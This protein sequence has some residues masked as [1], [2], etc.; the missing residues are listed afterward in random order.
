MKPKLTDQLADEIINKKKDL[1]VS[2]GITSEQEIFQHLEETIKDYKLYKKIIKLRSKGLT[3][4]KIGDMVGVHPGTVSHWADKGIIPDLIS[5]VSYFSKKGMNTSQSVETDLIRLL[6]YYCSCKKSL[7][8]STFT[9]S[10]YKKETLEQILPS[11]FNVFHT[12]PLIR[13]CHYG[14]DFHFNSNDFLNYIK[15]NT[16]DMTILPWHIL[17]TKEKKEEFFKY[18][19]MK[20]GKVSW[21]QGECKNPDPR[22]TFS[23]KM[24]PNL[25]PHF[26]MLLCDFSFVPRYSKT[27]IDLGDYLDLNSLIRRGLCI[28]SYK[29]NQLSVALKK[30]REY[31]TEKRPTYKD[32]FIVDIKEKYESKQISREKFIKVLERKKFSDK[33]IKNLLYSTRIPPRERRIK[34]LREVKKLVGDRDVY[35]HLYNNS[36]EPIGLNQIKDIAL[37]ADT[38]FIKIYETIESIALEIKSQNLTPKQPVFR[39]LTKNLDDK[40]AEEIIEKKKNLLITLG[41]N[42]TEVKKGLKNTLNSLKLYNQ[43]HELREKG[44]EPKEI[45]EILNMDSNKAEAWTTGGMI[46]IYFH[47]T[48]VFAEN[49]FNYKDRD[50]LAYLFGTLSATNFPK[51]THL[52]ISSFDLSVIQKIQCY[53]YRVTKSIP[54]ARI[55]EKG[56]WRCEWKSKKLA[57]LF[58][59]HTKDNSSIPWKILKTEK[60]MLNYFKAYSAKSGSVENR[61]IKNKSRQGFV[62][63]FRNRKHY[64]EE[65]ENFLQLIGFESSRNNTQVTIRK[66]E[67]LIR[68]VTKKLCDSDEKRI[69]LYK[70]IHEIAYEATMNRLEELIDKCKRVSAE[71]DDNWLKSMNKITFNSKLANMMQAEFIDPKTTYKNIVKKYHEM[72]DRKWNGRRPLGYEI[73]SIDHTKGK[74]KLKLS[75]DEAVDAESSENDFR[76]NT[77]YWAKKL[78]MNHAINIYYN[79]EQHSMI[80]STEDFE[81]KAF[82]EVYKLVLERELMQR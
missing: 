50:S 64:A 77:N 29:K 33:Y 3:T 67:D 45:G 51:D 73:K 58:N 72:L 46:P 41:F 22:I 63:S 4:T 35:A 28:N 31:I 42:E 16:L 70:A 60:Q 56:G 38:N 26:A 13:E 5:N 34:K 6:G 30:R 66:K 19:F 62:F 49:Y 7:Q 53:L 44:I 68:I 9:T 23:F 10:D 17:S 24:H 11:M 57:R 79:K 20:S 76:S 75:P 15:K 2:I 8:K 47:H 27:K 54:N 82:L 52:K 43:S 39:T 12:I 55:Y 18:W 80:F 71:I 81:S 36:D 37:V 25:Q 61:I 65:F 1:L 74:I 69:S 14:Y 40:L 59:K 21:K 32:G 78:E 48:G